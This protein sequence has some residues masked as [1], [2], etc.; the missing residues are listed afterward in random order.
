MEELRPSSSE[1]ASRDRL[2]QNDEADD[3]RDR[4]F[5]STLESLAG[6]RP[7]S[8][9]ELTEIAMTPFFG[10]R[11]SAELRALSAARHEAARVGVLRRWPVRRNRARRLRRAGRARAR[12]PGRPGD[13]SEPAA[14][15]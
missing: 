13:D 4:A 7:I 1:H 5:Y 14:V 2:V 6:P 15:G 8:I 11:F 9:E 10:G 3:N 12:S